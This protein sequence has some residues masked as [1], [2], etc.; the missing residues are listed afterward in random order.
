MRVLIRCIAIVISSLFCY[1]QSNAQIAY[2]SSCFKIYYVDLS[3]YN[4]VD[5]FTIPDNFTHFCAIAQNS[6]GLLYGMR[7]FFS[8][9]TTVNYDTLYTFN[10]VTKELAS[11]CVIKKNKV[12]LE[13]LSGLCFDDNDDLI[14]YGYDSITNT[15]HLYKFNINSCSFVQD[16]DLDTVMHF[17]SDFEYVNGFVYGTSEEV[18]WQF[19][20]DDSNSHPIP[21][22]NNP[23][24]IKYGGYIGLINNCINDTFSFM[25]VSQNFNDNGTIIYKFNPY[26][27]ARDSLAT[28]PF[29]ISDI[30]FYYPDVDENFFYLGR[31]TTICGGSP[32]KLT[33]KIPGT[34]WSTGQTAS[35]ITVNKAGKYWAT[36]TNSCGTFSDTIVIDTLVQQRLR[37]FNDTTVCRG[38]SLKYVSNL[39]NTK[40]NTQTADSIQFAA[41]RDTIIYVRAVYNCYPNDSMRDTITIKVDAL[42]TVNVTASATT[43]CNLPITLTKNISNAIW[44]T[45]ATSNSIFVNSAGKYWTSIT[46]ACGT[47]SDTVVVQS[48]SSTPLNIGRDT[49]ICANTSFVIHSNLAKTIWSTG[50]TAQQI[51]VNSAG[52]YWATIKDSCNTYTDTIHI[53]SYIPET[54]ILSKDTV[55]CPNTTITISSSNA[56]TQFGNG[57]VSNQLIITVTKDTVIVGKVTN[58]CAASG[59]NT[60]TVSIKTI[61]DEPLILSSATKVICDSETVVL[62][63]SIQNTIWTLPDSSTIADKS[64][65]I[66]K[67]GTYVASYEGTCANYSD[68]IIITQYCTNYCA[69]YL[70]TAF[71]PNGDNVNDMFQIFADCKHLDAFNFK[72]YNRWSELVFESDDVLKG[73]DGTYKGQDI[74]LDTYTWYLEFI[75]NDIKQVKKGIVTVIR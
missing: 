25:V 2:V 69:L 20:M 61:K 1:K 29:T 59:F 28:I 67:T 18:I 13:N 4:I 36:Y 7:F 51:T 3:T 21:I 40:W 71:S 56:N 14:F 23:T 9:D 74:P 38:T 73:W 54:I 31:D 32:Y 63:S 62:N 30:A 26:T 8:S 5:E 70:P 48:F 33:T 60:D 43:Y 39:H 72:I 24:D 65:L 57:I 6:D 45:G 52:T 53:S 10:P 47:F 42:Q 34:K 12:S 17:D 37:S 66:N 19:D 46:N 68:S 41:Q 75:T 49:A 16:H 22:Y 11:S 64:I 50:D 15:D 44:N 58:R 55:V 35:Y 27:G